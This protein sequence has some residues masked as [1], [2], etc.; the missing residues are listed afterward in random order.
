MALIPKIARKL[1]RLGNL[2]SKFGDPRRLPVVLLS[3][4]GITTVIDPVPEVTRITPQQLEQF[5]VAS[6]QVKPT[7]WVIAE[8][9]RFIYSDTLLMK[10]R[11]LID[12]ELSGG[13]YT[14]LPAEFRY[15]D[16]KDPLYYKV[17]VAG[18]L[19]R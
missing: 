7:D 9:P 8:I 16:D 3:Q 10:A 19:L 2:N 17:V 18:H 15:L 12:A 4:G 6:I 5:N 13:S 14:G 11:Y 1:Y